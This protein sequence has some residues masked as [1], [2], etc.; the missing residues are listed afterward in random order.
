MRINQMPDAPD[1]RMPMEL[2]VPCF[3][4]LSSFELLLR[5]RLIVVERHA[6]GRG[7]LGAREGTGV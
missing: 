3:K 1:R 5:L 7:T 2:A 4:I 6:H